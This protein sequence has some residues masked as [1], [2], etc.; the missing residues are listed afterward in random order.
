MLDDPL[1]DALISGVIVSVLA[2]TL[3]LRSIA[4]LGAVSVLLVHTAVH[5][6]HLRLTE[7][8]GASRVL[9]ALAALLSVGAIVLTLVD[10]S[11]SS[12]MILE[13][14]GGVIAAAFVFELG[15]RWWGRGELK[16]RTV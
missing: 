7:E 5:V 14:F 15:M 12:F 1:D 9:V 4:V 11:Q 2:A 8:T 13:M 10:A 16:T 6:G 3:D